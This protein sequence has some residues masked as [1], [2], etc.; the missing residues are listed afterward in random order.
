MI[1]LDTIL[2]DQIKDKSREPSLEGDGELSVADI[3]TKYVATQVY[4]L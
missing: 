1:D 4:S 2:S 3:G